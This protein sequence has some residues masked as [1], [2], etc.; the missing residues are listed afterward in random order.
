MVIARQISSSVP[1]PLLAGNGDEVI[2]YV[3]RAQS[4]G[5]LILQFSLIGFSF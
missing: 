2:C 5:N 1:G 4:S 3:T